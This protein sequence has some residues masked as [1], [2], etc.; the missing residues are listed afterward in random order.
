MLARNF[1][2]FAICL[3]VILGFVICHDEEDGEDPYTTTDPK[4]REPSP[5]ESKFKKLHDQR[6]YDLAYKV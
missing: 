1:I 4:K 5:C 3:S 2:G 6:F